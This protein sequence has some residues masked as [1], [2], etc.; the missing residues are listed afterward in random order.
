MER[1]LIR[2]V[3]PAKLKDADLEARYVFRLQTL[4]ALLHFKFHGLPFIQR[5]VAVHG[6]RGEVYEY[7]LS[8]LPLDKAETL[9]RV[10]PLY[11]SLFLH[12]WTSYA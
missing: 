12:R 3:R 11:S 8:R 10:K 1:V 6:D 5:F 7:I 4:W 2:R 9:R